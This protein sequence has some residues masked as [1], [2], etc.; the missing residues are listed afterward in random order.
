MKP[1]AETTRVVARD[2]A[3]DEIRTLK[4]GDGGDILM[5][6]SATAWNPLMVAGLVDEL[7][8][9][10]GAALMG[11]GSP[12][13]SGPRIGLDLVSARTVPN[14]QLVELRYAPEGG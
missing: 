12:L 13:Y 11:S 8:V 9:L 7:I 4:A 14:S 10:V 1:W 3:I 2:D 5:F 6:G